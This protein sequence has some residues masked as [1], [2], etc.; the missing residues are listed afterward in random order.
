MLNDKEQVSNAVG[1][2]T[3]DEDN[4]LCE[5]LCVHGMGNNKVL[6]SFSRT[7]TAL[8]F[9]DRI[10]TKKHSILTTNSSLPRQE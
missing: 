4:H 5:G 8:P 1:G 10:Y 7:R 9:S 3:E 6:R 2:W